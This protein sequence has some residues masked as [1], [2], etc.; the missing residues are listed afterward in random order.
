MKE[1]KNPK[2]YIRD[3]SGLRQQALE[4][5]NIIDITYLS[6]NCL[7]ITKEG[8]VFLCSIENSKQLKLYLLYQEDQTPI[9]LID[10]GFHHCIL[11]KES[12]NVYAYGTNN[13]SNELGSRFIITNDNEIQPLERMNKIVKENNSKVTH[14]SCSINS[15]FIVLNNTD[16]YF[17]G[18]LHYLKKDNFARIEIENKENCKIKRITCGFNHVLVIYEDG[19]IYGQGGN[20]YGQSVINNSNRDI[21]SFEKVDLNEYF[22]KKKI[23]DAIAFRKSHMTLFISSENDFYIYGYIGFNETL[24]FSNHTKIATNSHNCDIYKLEFQNLQPY[25]EF[26]KLDYNRNFKEWEMYG[27]YT[28]LFIVNNRKGKVWAV[29]RTSVTDNNG[30]TLIDGLELN[31]KE[32]VIKISSGTNDFGILVAEGYF[33]SEE[34]MKKKLLIYCNA[35]FEK[36]NLFLFD[37]SIN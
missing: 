25:D 2:V 15:S 18:S 17:S 32:K 12:N 10:S 1:L 11:V 14:V 3:G 24:T 16:I 23:V 9:K 22:K 27:A 26:Y 36:E 21:N 6:D 4:K 20:D 7:V 28:S 35:C 31:E 19:D 29:G 8:N 5:E 37:I 13:N 30:F 34:E 33:K